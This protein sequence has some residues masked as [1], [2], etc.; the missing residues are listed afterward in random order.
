MF[1]VASKY[2]KREVLQRQLSYLR[3]KEKK[4]LRIEPHGSNNKKRKIDRHVTTNVEQ[5]TRHRLL[6][7]KQEEVQRL[8]THLPFSIINVI[9]KLIIFTI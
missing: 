7:H 4:E 6:V 3:D 1:Q 9:T 8:W 5:K 2:T